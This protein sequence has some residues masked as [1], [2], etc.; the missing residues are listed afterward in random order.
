MNLKQ[1]EAFDAFMSHGSATR[2]AA[3]LKISQPMVSRLLGQLEETIGFPLF[4]RKRNQLMPTHE[5]ILFHTNVSRSLTAFQ[6]LEREARAIANRQVGRIVVAAQPIY[7][8]TFLLD[9]VA[10]FKQTHP[11]VAVKI[12]DTGLEELLRMFNEG[13][14][15][16]GVGITLD[17]SPY[18][19]SLINLG[20]CE[21]RCLIPKGHRLAGRDVVQ[22]EDLRREVFVELAIGSPL[23]TRV[24]YMMQTAGAQRQIAAE[25]RTLRAVHG[26]VRRGVGIAIVD[27][28]SSLLPSGDDVIERP[29]KPSIPWEMAIFHHEDR[30]LSRIENAFIDTIR[31][32]I[33]MLREQGVLS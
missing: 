24:D 4:V 18:G 8:D 17:A 33:G 15:D 7:V 23:R 1:L 25:A 30:P 14:C 2:A 9:V 29:L 26:L 16:L 22:I 5:A 27:P 32:E 12:V 3:A 11:D 10:R 31:A 21:A 19:A 28:F 20:A 13:S 6:E